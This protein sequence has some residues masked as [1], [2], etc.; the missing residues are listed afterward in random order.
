MITLGE[1]RFGAIRAAWGEIRR[2]ALDDHL[3]TYVALPVDSSVAE[4]WAHLRA[5]C[6]ELGRPKDDNDLWIA[7]TAERYEIPLAT[8]D[9]DHHD[10]PGLTVI[11]EDGS[12]VSVPE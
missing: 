11:R 5:R 12:E 10:I 9:R 7:A 1:M 6:F 3:E 8:L 4:L 2:R